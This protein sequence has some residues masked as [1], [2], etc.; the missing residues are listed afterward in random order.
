MGCN[1]CKVCFEHMIYS[2]DLR[3]ST[4]VPLTGQVLPIYSA[5]GHVLHKVLGLGNLVV[6]KTSIFH[7]SS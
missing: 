3:S 2:M 6:I 4:T 7:T 5:T 1:V